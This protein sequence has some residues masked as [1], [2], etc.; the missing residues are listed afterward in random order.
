MDKRQTE[1]GMIN[2]IGT[3][4]LIIFFIFCI[5]TRNFALF[6]IVVGVGGFCWVLIGNMFEAAYKAGTKVKNT[7]TVVKQYIPGKVTQEGTK[8]SGPIPTERVHTKVESVKNEIVAG[9]DEPPAI[10]LSNDTRKNTTNAM[11]V[12]QKR[13]EFVMPTGAN[14]PI[15]FDGKKWHHIALGKD[16]HYCI[17]GTT[18]SGKGNALQLIALSA[19]QL[20]QEYVHLVILDAKGGVD[21]TFAKK[22]QHADLY[23]RDTL[24]FG[25]EWIISEMNRR[26]DLIESVDARNI[27]EYYTKTGERIPYLIVIADEIADFNKKMSTNIETF[28]RMSR[29]AGGVLFVAT[30]YPTEEVLSNQIQANVTN[31]C[32]FRLV[33]SEHSR[34]AMRRTKADGGIYEPASIDASLPGTAVLRRDGGREVLGRASELTDEIRDNW[35]NS[36]AS[37]YPKLNETPQN[38]AQR[39]TEVS[40]K[41]LTTR[42][43]SEEEMIMINDWIAEFENVGETRYRLKVTKKLYNHR[44]GKDAQ[45]DGRGQLYQIVQA[46][47]DGETA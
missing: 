46:Y 41:G 25:C 28:A 6:L 36:L 9:E 3:L 13:I 39:V 29:A 18:G 47:L 35:I 34:V 8:P 31:R 22:I 24:E 7:A 27:H 15:L 14:I 2:G 37:K 11:K 21:Y 45:Y 16:G 20:G 19:I 44:G 4:S 43:L 40:E 26:L 33:S 42:P 12:L 10:T 38:G 1:G 23:R 17:S 32:V 5:A 30:Q